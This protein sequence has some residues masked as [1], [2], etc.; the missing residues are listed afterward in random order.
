MMWL[1]T[2]RLDTC[3]PSAMPTKTS[4]PE[5]DPSVNTVG[6]D[7]RTVRTGDLWQLGD[8]KIVCGDSSDATVIAA[9]MEAETATMMFADPPYGVHYVGKRVAR[10]AIANDDATAEELQHLLQNAFTAAPLRPG[11]AFYVCC[12]SNDNEMAFRQALSSSGLSVRQQIVWVKNH[13]VLSRQDYHWKHEV[14]QYGWKNGASHYFVD[15][16]T[17]HTVWHAN[18][19]QRSALHPTM[20]PIELVI[21]AISN[22]SL[23]GEIVFDG[24]GGSGT[25]L[26]ACERLGRRCRMVEIDPHYVASII[27][28]WETDTGKSATLVRQIGNSLESDR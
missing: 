18:K 19:P 13:F 5:A 26:V 20:K 15:D 6:E 12:P 9:L 2:V 21:R 24:F 10:R 7:T 23:P 16:R 27:S 3:K 22:S 14:M 1:G 8:H 11:A 4:P 17:Q 28:R 25:T